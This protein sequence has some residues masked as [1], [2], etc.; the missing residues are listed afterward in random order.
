MTLLLDPTKA[1]QY[2]AFRLMLLFLQEHSQYNDITQI[3]KKN[4]EQ[5]IEFFMIFQNERGAL[6]SP[7][8]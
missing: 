1:V 5:L 2:E 6:L 3:L 8:L 7:T 4:Q